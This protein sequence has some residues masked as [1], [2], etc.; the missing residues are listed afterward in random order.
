MLAFN[1]WAIGTPRLL[2]RPLQK[3]D[4]DVVFGIFSD[5][6]VMWYWPYKPGESTEQVHATIKRSQSAMA[7][8]EQSGARS[9]PNSVAVFQKLYGNRLD[10]LQSNP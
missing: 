9:S 1:E 2:L 4:A 8:W 7:A 5:T 10:L 6:A 3:S